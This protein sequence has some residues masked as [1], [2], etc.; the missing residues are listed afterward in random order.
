MKSGKLMRLPR[1]RR[2]KGFY[3]AVA[4]LSLLAF[5]SLFPLVLVLLNSFKTH[6]EIARNPLTL[7]RSFSLKNYIYTWKVGNFSDGFIN[8][9]KVTGTAIVTGVIAAST[10]GFVLATRRV[11]TW[12]PMTLYFMMATTV[13][14]QMFMLPLYSTF[15]RTGM[16]GNHFAV[17]AVIAAWNLPMP[18]FL[19][20]TYF[21]KVP[22]ELEEAARID[23]ATT[24]QVFTKVMM[25]IVSPGMI[26]VAVIVGLFS[27][28]EY[29]LT[30][31]LLQG[32]AN[33]TATLK[34]LNLNGTFSRDFAVIMAGAVIMILPMIIVFLLL[35]RKFI[36]GMSA[37]AVKG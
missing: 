22:M 1:K 8:S 28:N 30:S 16:L 5:I 14:L 2:E 34:Y 25:P 9:L 36:E 23:G 26:T 21:L 4:V 17:G 37:G 15:V 31:L 3:F 7:P 24:F 18:I 11:R 33:F 13:P 6:A 29:L 27:W 10:M 19:M 12:K 35:Q 32:D 20:R